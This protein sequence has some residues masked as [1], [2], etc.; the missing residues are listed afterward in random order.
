[1]PEGVYAVATV[2]FDDQ[3]RSCRAEWQ[4]RAKAEPARS[5]GGPH[6]IVDRLTVLLHAAPLNQSQSALGPRDVA[7]LTDALSSI[8]ERLPARETRLVVFSLA[9]RKELLRQEGFR[10]EGMD[11]LTQF[12]E[13]LQPGAVD[14]QTLA[15]PHGAYDL[16]ARLL[17]RERT[18]GDPPGAI[19]LLGPPGNTA[20]RPPVQAGEMAAKLA[21][22]LFYIELGAHSNG[23]PGATPPGIPKT[24]R[25]ARNE[26]DAIEIAVRRPGSDP[27]GTRDIAANQFNTIRYTISRLKGK[28]FLVWRPEDFAKAVHEIDTALG[29][30]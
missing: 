5:V 8:L 24:G 16:L 4:I 21:P 12:L 23:A 14:V 2:V 30:H 17:D 19:V 11:R 1:V 26:I 9:E 27:P 18:G 25:A 15:N 3:W 13:G 22:R 29:K 7:V 28:S 6:P 10:L 20:E